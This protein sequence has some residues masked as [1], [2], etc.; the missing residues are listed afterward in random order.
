[1]PNNSKK[2]SKA[3]NTDCMFF[4]S[5]YEENCSACKICNCR[6]CA[7]MVPKD[8]QRQKALMNEYKEHINLMYYPNGTR[9]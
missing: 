8:E 2:L 3:T 1:M 5:S 9:R 7:F 4:D 6:N